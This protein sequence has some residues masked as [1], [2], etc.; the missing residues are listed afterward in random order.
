MI[1]NADFDGIAGRT[2]LAI[3]SLN[4]R[5]VERSSAAAGA[6]VE[7][8]RSPQQR[9]PVGGVVGVQRDVRHERL[10]LRV[11]QMLSFLKILYHDVK[12]TNRSKILKII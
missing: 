7:G 11:R 12:G 10:H 1:R 6:K 5:N 8:P 2:M 3:P 9:D 4:E